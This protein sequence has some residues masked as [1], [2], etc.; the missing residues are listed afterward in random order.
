QMLAAAKA[1]ANIIAA[2]ELSG[3]DLTQGGSFDSIIELAQKTAQDAVNGITPPTAA[4]YA[5]SHGGQ[6]ARIDY[7]AAK[8]AFADFDA[9]G[10]FVRYHITETNLSQLLGSGDYFG[11]GLAGA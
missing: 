6:F 4:A 5:A 11:A 8:G 9:N 10:V 1:V 3:V 2:A 7:A